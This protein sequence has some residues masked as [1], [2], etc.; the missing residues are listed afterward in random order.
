MRA[1]NGI[2]MKYIVLLTAVILGGCGACGSDVVDHEISPNGELKAVSYL[3]DCGA[4]SGFSTQVSII[5]ASEEI[6]SS[7]NVLVTDGKNKIRV[8]WLS[9]SELTIKNTI[10]LKSFKKVDDYDGINISYK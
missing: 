6:T 3:Y 9:D 5:D 4:T 1:L 8:K 10:G 2:A 7:G